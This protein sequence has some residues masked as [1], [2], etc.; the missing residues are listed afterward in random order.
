[1][2]KTPSVSY[3]LLALIL[4][5]TIG[6]LCADFLAPLGIAG[7]V[8]Y[9][10]VVLLSV[11]A[12]R[13]RFTLSVALLVSALTIGGHFISPSG[14]EVWVDT[15]N[16]L[17]ALFV[18]WVTTLL[19]L[20][21]QRAE[22]E[23][24][25]LARRV[26]ARERLALLGEMSAGVA[27]EFRNPLHGVLNCMEMLRV[28]LGTDEDSRELFDLADEGLRRMDEISARM[29]SLGREEKN[30]KVATAAGQV[31]QNAVAMIRLRAQKENVLL[32]VDVE[33]GLPK[34]DM[35]ASRVTEAVLNLLTNAL[36]ACGPGGHVMVR[37]RK[38]A[39]QRD[40]VQI[41]VLDNGKGIPP[42]VRK[43][44]FEPFFT[45]KPV[46]KGAGLGLVIARAVAENHGGMVVLVQRP[47]GGAS[48]VLSLPTTMH[49]AVKTGG[50]AT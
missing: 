26:A 16:R 20:A 25:R 4:I 28:R 15:V 45:T 49:A 10:V 2:P 43:R 13:Q 32:E 3:W 8:P 12:L 5:L 14:S 1:M 31:V 34:V 21:R 6:I 47:E 39:E 22:E 48:A 42:D 50:G 36:D 38:H 29:L 19:L 11:G 44:L 40:V 46:G 18:I 33:V 37:V 30:P 9:V 24:A 35:D 17:L 7:G 41:E 27:H 23:R